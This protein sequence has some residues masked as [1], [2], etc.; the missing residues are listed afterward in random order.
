M[1][2]ITLWFLLM[3]LVAVICF[4]ETT[5]DTNIEIP[6]S[7]DDTAYVY[8]VDKGT[9]WGKL[10]YD[11]NNTTNK[12]KKV[13]CLDDEDNVIDDLGLYEDAIDSEIDFYDSGM[14]AYEEASESDKAKVAPFLD[15]AKKKDRKN[16]RWKN[17]FNA[18]KN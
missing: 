14:D 15:T 8:L 7:K 10:H 13:E 18:I 11:V 16:N 4:G 6:Q 3:F 9:S 12:V 5:D 2:K 17:R 1:K